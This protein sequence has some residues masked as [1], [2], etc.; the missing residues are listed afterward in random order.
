[1]A[2]SHIPSRLRARGRTKLMLRDSPRTQSYLKTHVS[3][4]GMEDL[5]PCSSQRIQGGARGKRARASR[6]RSR[7]LAII[8]ATPYPRCFIKTLI[9]GVHA[10][11]RKKLSIYDEVQ[12]RSGLGWL[13][14]LA[15]RTSPRRCTLL[16][17]VCNELVGN[18]RALWHAPDIYL[19][20]C[21]SRLHC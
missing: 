11:A 16:A 2:H 8:C 5:E 10:C 14:Q 20:G 21:T 3:T 17:R 4:S 18:A 9:T 6:V 13:A 15:P 19:Q 7:T 1:V 12:Q